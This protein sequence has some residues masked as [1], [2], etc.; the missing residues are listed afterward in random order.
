MV[1]ALMSGGGKN[2]TLALDRARRD[3]M[4]V[5]Y[6]VSIYAGPLELTRFHGT[7]R[8]LVERQAKNLG[9]E[10]IAVQT[11]TLDLETAFQESLRRLNELE[12][13]GV[14]FG[15]IGLDSVRTWYEDRV[16]AAGLEHIEPNWGEPSIE[17]AWEVVERGYQALVVSVNRAQR[18]A[19]FLGREFDADLVTEIGCTDGIDPS[20]ERGE[21][22]TFVFDG[23]AF[24][25]PV[26][27][28]S[29]GEFEFEAHRLIELAPPKTVDS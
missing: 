18:A 6:L 9:L 22:H 11:T 4:D 1:Y 23:P 29:G 17:I 24:T 5:G 21:Y 26:G 10:P 16:S 19:E 13:K 12:V 27:F 2:S 8:A 7:P 15:D 14:I 20:G 3:R 25:C 28:S